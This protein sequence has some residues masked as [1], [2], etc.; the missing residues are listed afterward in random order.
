MLLQS[1]YSLAAQFPGLLR[2]P[3]LVRS[4]LLL[5]VL[6][7]L[8]L[9]TGVCSCSK[10]EAAPNPEPSP[11]LS[12]GDRVVV[13]QTAAHFFEGR[14][15]AS[16]AGRLRVQAADGSDSLSV[17]PSDVYRLPPISRELTPGALAVCGR[18][19]DWVPCRLVTVSGAAISAATASGEPIELTRE[20]VIWPS[21]LT[22][23]NLKRYFARS[24]AE[25]D[26]SRSASN[27][28]EPRQEPGW[29]PSKH[30]RLLAKIGRDWFTAYVRE[31]GEDSV[32]VTLSVAQRVA[33]VPASA[34]APEP[35]SS[36][37]ADLHRGDFVLVRPE[38]PS[39]PW[40]RRLVRAV[41]PTELKLSDATGAV[42][43]A[44]PREV[45]PLRP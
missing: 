18:V 17:A 22:E 27:A 42:K 20:R 9:I 13:E 39:D 26:F 38:T 8:S 1:I 41:N 24:E 43:M 2:A 29:H 10:R 44:S 3:W 23:L 4:L 14:V 28:G 34:V 37:A 16:E 25:L 30:E 21:P 33:T 35:P 5:P 19:D 11:A 31:L 15:L 40:S 45:V 36:F 6:P 32:V 7:A 12:R